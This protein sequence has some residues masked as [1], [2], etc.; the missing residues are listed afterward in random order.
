MSE[1]NSSLWN[2]FI[3]CTHNCALSIQLRIVLIRLGERLINGV[4]AYGRRERARNCAERQKPMQDADPANDPPPGAPRIHYQCGNNTQQLAEAK[5]LAIHFIRE[6][7]ST[8]A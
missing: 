1:C 6:K 8:G 2:A 4:S 5:S 7:I 3:G